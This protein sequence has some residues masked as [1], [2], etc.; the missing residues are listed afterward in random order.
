MGSHVHLPLAPLFLSL[1]LPHHL[2]LPCPPLLEEDVTDTGQ[3]SFEDG[4]ESSSGSQDLEEHRMIV[5]EENEP[6][7]P[8]S[9]ANS[10]PCLLL[11][12]ASPAQL[13]GSPN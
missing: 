12:G 1:S 5:G 3:G 8:L 6:A 10:P 13:Q 4:R 2:H 9:G 7:K 11:P